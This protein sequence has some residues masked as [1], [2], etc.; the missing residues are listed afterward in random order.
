MPFDYYLV[1]KRGRGHYLGR[2]EVR[3]SALGYLINASTYCRFFIDTM[4]SFNLLSA[5]IFLLIALSPSECSV[6]AACCLRKPV[7]QTCKVACP[8]LLPSLQSKGLWVTQTGLASKHSTLPPRSGDAT[9]ASKFLSLRLQWSGDGV[10]G[11]GPF[12]RPLKRG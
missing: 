12:R 2:Q 3:L 8:C 7:V 9:R 6:P 4:P 11:W 10:R 1:Q 5:C